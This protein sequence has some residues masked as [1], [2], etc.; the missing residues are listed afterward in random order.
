MHLL[1]QASAVTTYNC[2]QFFCSAFV[3]GWP[4]HF[5][6]GTQNPSHVPT[7]LKPACD[8]LTLWLNQTFSPW[9]LGWF[10]KIVLHDVTQRSGVFDVSKF[11]LETS[12]LCLN[13]NPKKSKG[14]VWKNVRQRG[15]NM[16]INTWFKCTLTVS[17]SVQVTLQRK[18]LLMGR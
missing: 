18:I 15:K 3:C 9:Y 12:I 16:D 7:V 10:F 11:S 8:S 6:S 1:K 2:N 17:S 14:S 13:S 5:I 4:A